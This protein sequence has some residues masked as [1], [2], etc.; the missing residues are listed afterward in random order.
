MSRVKIDTITAVHIGNGNTL[1]YNNDF[2]VSDDYIYII[3][4]S[5]IL[6]LI[7]TAELD[8]WL[9]VIERGK[10]QA[11]YVKN[12]TEALPS[13]Y[14]KRKLEKFCEEIFHRDTLKETI[15]NG[16][17][18]P[19]IPGSSI[20]GAIRT[21]LLA[22]LL[23]KRTGLENKIKN[24]RGNVTSSIL[25]GELFGAN[26][27]T[28]I[29]KNLQVGD[30]YFEKG[31]EV[32]MRMIKGLNITHSD[33][34]QP[35]KIENQ[36]IVEAINQ[37]SKSELRMKLASKPGMPEEMQSLNTLF[38]CVNNH[39]KQLLQS[40][41]AFWEAQ[42]EEK[43]GAE[44]YIETIDG[45]LSMAEKCNANECIL[46]VGHASGWRFTTG[47]WAENLKNFEDVVVNASRRN[48]YNYKEYPFPKSRRID[49]EGFLL[50]FVKLTIEE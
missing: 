20:K 32:A 35:D 14:S 36:Q 43:D 40:E 2:V 6:E 1:K 24:E 3:D 48:N 49:E 38:S 9:A 18:L 21:A 29:F 31:S 10:S 37:D 39:T 23:N 41:I 17:G 27:Q 7:G 45:I 4:P 33:N 22:T 15:H 50:G 13:K 47:A 44:V 42:S 26:P 25:E 8:S 19:Y 16:M 34:L 5:K 11:E 46:R 30:A 12:K 28:D